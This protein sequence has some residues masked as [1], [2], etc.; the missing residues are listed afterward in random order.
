MVYYHPA[1]T[2]PVEQMITIEQQQRE[3]SLSPD[4]LEQRLF[5]QQI[6]SDNA[7]DDESF[8]SS[9]SSLVDSISIDQPKS[10]QRHLNSTKTINKT[11]TS[12]SF[13]NNLAFLNDANFVNDDDN[14]IDDE[15]TE[16]HFDQDEVNLLFSDPDDNILCQ[17][18]HELIDA[19]DDNNDFCKH[20]RPLPCVTSSDLLISLSSSIQDQQQLYSSYHFLDPIS[21][22]ASEEERRAAA[23]INLQQQKHQH[24]T[25]S[26]SSSLSISV[27]GYRDGDT[28]TIDD[29]ST[30]SDIDEQNSSTDENSRSQT[31]SISHD[32]QHKH[33]RR[34]HNEIHSIHWSTTNESKLNY[35]YLFISIMKIKLTIVRFNIVGLACRKEKGV[36]KHQVSDY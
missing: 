3:C 24:S 34:C 26:S 28:T 36:N 7:D 1:A 30:L 8:L 21:E 32:R 11:F 33:K 23:S 14:D 17:L 29:L 16:I 35:Y 12:R 31:S 4:S 19:D 15:L 2:V 25:S 6:I 9:S 13:F 20:I 27:N 22:A 5:K 10:Q 18:S